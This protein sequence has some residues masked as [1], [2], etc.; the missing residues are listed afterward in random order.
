MRVRGEEGRNER[1]IRKIVLKER[2][3]GERIIEGKEE[4]RREGERKRYMGPI[5]FQHLLSSRY[6]LVYILRVYQFLH[7][8][9]FRASNKKI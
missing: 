4:E 1:A 5:F 3:D 8:R 2:G 9:A 7:S 6:T